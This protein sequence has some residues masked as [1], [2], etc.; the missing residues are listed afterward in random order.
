MNL[1]LLI[2]QPFGIKK[3]DHTYLDPNKPNT[4]P[5]MWETMPANLASR[6][7]AAIGPRAK[8]QKEIVQCMPENNANNNLPRCHYLSMRINLPRGSVFAF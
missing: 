2:Y 4:F 8:L 6:N 3:D 5:K 1:N 7:W